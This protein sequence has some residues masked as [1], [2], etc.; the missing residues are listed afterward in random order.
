MIGKC[1]G[2]AWSLEPGALSLEIDHIFFVM[3]RDYLSTL[4]DELVLHI[5]YFMDPMSVARNL[6][7]RN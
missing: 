5:M 3:N 1:I 6:E 4:P 2:G 7:L